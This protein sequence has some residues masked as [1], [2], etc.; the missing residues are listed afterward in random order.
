[1]VAGHVFLHHSG[2]QD[3][4]MVAY[5]AGEKVKDPEEIKNIIA[6]QLSDIGESTDLL[7]QTVSDDFDDLREALISDDI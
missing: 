7:A 5:V 1:L 2:Q 4:G 6:I 3:A